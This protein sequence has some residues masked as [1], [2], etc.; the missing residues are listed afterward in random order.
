MVEPNVTY[1]TQPPQTLDALQAARTLGELLS[2]TPEYRAFLETLEAVN[3]DLTVQKLAAEMRSHQTAL[4]WGRDP[5]GKHEAE[6]ARL[7][8]EIESLPV[9]QQYR[10]AEQGVIAL[11]CAVDE[12][13]SREAG[14]DFAANAKRSCCG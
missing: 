1:L 10:Q 11:F 14:V 4:Q 8:A 7:E 12:I 2:A 3:R 6:L 5:D 13:I 9:V